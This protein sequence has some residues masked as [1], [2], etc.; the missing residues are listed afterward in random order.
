MPAS[1]IAALKERRVIA[2]DTLE[3][4]LQRPDAFDFQAG[5]NVNLKLTELPF[6]D[7]RHGRRMLTIASAPNDQDLIFATRMTGSGFKRSLLQG[8]LQDIE[9]IGPRGNM[10]RDADKSAVF[11][12][13]GIGITPFKSMVLDA[14]NRKLTPPTTLLYSNKTP[15]NAAYHQLFA[16]LEK[17]NS[18]RFKY[19]PT[20]TGSLDEGTWQGEHRR[21]DARF[22]RDHVADF[23]NAVFYV[24]GPPKMVDAIV[25][26]LKNENVTQ[27]RILSESFWGYM[28]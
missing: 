6:E 18:E 16:E 5:Q 11:I 25:E 19:V 10:V 14:V 27:E 22:V 23:D 2:E 12:A 20:M 17:N 26:M 7:K 4:V 28:S 15:A 13:G 21:I 9:I 1:Y 3:F 8:P 24:C